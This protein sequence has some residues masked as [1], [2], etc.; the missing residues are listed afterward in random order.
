MKGVKQM[1]KAKASTS[2]P[3][4]KQNIQQIKTQQTQPEVS[5]HLVKVVF[6]SCSI[7]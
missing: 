1:Q 5:V 2:T 4:N 6:Y 3:L 7:F